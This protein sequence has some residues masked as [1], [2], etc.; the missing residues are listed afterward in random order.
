MLGAEVFSPLADAHQVLGGDLAA[1]RL[2]VEAGERLQ[3]VEH[4]LAG[5]RGAGG[6]G[7]GGVRTGE[8]KDV[9]VLEEVLA[10]SYRK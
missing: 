4:H 9:L 1:V 3:R 10:G 2:L 8:V 5:R 7:A 6:D